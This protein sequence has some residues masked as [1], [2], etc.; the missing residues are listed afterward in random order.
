MQRTLR[1]TVKSIKN[2]S[3]ICAMGHLELNGFR[4]HRGHVMEDGMDVRTY[5][6]SLTKYSRDTTIHGQTTEK[7]S[8]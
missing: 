5:L 8:T 6:T 4:A 3:S 2:T 1:D 7:S